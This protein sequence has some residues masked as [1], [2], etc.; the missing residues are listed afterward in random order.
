MLAKTILFSYMLNQ[1]DNCQNNCH[2]QQDINQPAQD[3]RNQAQHKQ[4]QDDNDND[5]EPIRHNNLPLFIAFY[6]KSIVGSRSS[7][8]KIPDNSQD[9]NDNQINT[10]QVVKNLGENHYNDSKNEAGYTHP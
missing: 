4:N 6:Q 10:H 5:P 2:Y 7:S 8:I 9:A 3:V 1:P